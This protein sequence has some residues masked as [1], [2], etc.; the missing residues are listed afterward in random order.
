MI[1]FLHI[2]L[3][4]A[5]IPAFMGNIK[6]CSEMEKARTHAL[7]DF[8]IWRGAGTGSKLLHDQGAL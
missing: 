6:A 7:L 8:V 5:P 4:N 1:S 3:T 2:T